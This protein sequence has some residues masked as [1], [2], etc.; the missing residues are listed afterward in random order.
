MT[1]PDPCREMTPEDLTPRRPAEQLVSPTTD[2]GLLRRTRLRAAQARAADALTFVAETA[3]TVSPAYLGGDDR[4][5]VLLHVDLAALSEADPTATPDPTAAA[6]PTRRSHLEDGPAIS[7]EAARRMTCHAGVVALLRGPRG[8]L[9]DIGRRSG[10]IPPAIGRALRVR[11][12]G[13]CRFP[14]CQRRKGVEAHHIVHWA[15]GGP[16]RL[17]NLVLLCRL[18]HWLVHEGGFAVRG[19]VGQQ[20]EFR[21]PDGGLLP[22]V[23]DTHQQPAAALADRLHGEADALTPAW[24]YGEPLR[25]AYVVSAVLDARSRPT[26]SGLAA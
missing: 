18:H 1:G 23:P 14:G 21:R 20:V 4:Y 9:L 13:R 7:A 3:L 15:H 26:D 2:P 19:P 5:R 16:T 12:H 22:E 24:W 10:T 25:L 11:D 17:D 8:Q 6:D